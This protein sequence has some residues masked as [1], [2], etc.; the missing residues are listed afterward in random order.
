M[1]TDSLRSDVR[2]FV[3]TALLDQTADRSPMTLED[4]ALSLREWSLLDVDYPAGL[5]A[6]LLMEVWNAMID[7]PSAVCYNDQTEKKEDTTMT[8]S[9]IR[10]A[11]LALDAEPSFDTFEAA[12][13][14]RLFPDLCEALHVSMTDYPSFG[15]LFYALIDAAAS[16]GVDVS[17]IG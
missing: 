2:S 10:S 8:N 15:D 13:N 6:P 4:A 5:T 14:Y 17:G 16:A 3:A 7:G 11:L 12:P 1:Y 9:E